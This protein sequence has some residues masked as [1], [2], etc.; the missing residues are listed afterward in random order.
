MKKIYLV[1]MYLICGFYA[2]SGVAGLPGMPGKQPDFS[3]FLNQLRNN[4]S[5]SSGQTSSPSLLGQQPQLSQPQSNGQPAQVSAQNNIAPQTPPATDG[6]ALNFADPKEFFASASKTPTNII[7]SNASNAIVAYVKIEEA[8]RILDNALAFVIKDSERV[9]CVGSINGSPKVGYVDSLPNGG[10]TTC[11]IYDQAK[12]A[13]EPNQDF[14]IPISTG[15]IKW[16][17]NE[18]VQPDQWLT[19]REGVLPSADQNGATGFCA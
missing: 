16:V 15:P 7:P 2:Y 8:Q 9:A 10:G 13:Y 19:G 11:M 4:N 1:A 18:Q 12:L 6:A 14:T 5:A 3:D 17:K